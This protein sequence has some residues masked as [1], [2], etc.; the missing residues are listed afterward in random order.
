[1]SVYTELAVPNCTGNRSYGGLRMQLPVGHMVVLSVTLDPTKEP[2]AKDDISKEI[3]KS[4]I[5]CHT[6]ELTRVGL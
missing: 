5:Q 3:I 1:M 6:A 4:K 2:V